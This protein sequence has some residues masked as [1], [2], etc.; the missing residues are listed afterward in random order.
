MMKAEQ[1]QSSLTFVLS[2][3]PYLQK[4][5]RNQ[6]H[7][8]HFIEA[9]ATSLPR[10]GYEIFILMEFCAGGGIIDLMNARLRDRLREEEVLKIFADVCDGLSVMHHLDPPMMHRDLKVE[11]ILLAP[12]STKSGPPVYKLCDFGSASPVLSR[13]APK[14]V[15]EIKRV[16]ADLNK[17]T[18]LQYRAPEMVDPYQRRVIDEKADIW[19]LGVLLYKLCYY[20]TPFE[21][22]GG[23]PLAILNARYRFPPH[24]PYSQRI[25][26]LIGEFLEIRK[27]NSRSHLAVSD[28]FPSRKSSSP[29]FQPLYFKNNLQL[30]L[31]LTKS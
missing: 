29:P 25:K 2:L 15:D 28:R 9:S 30:D 18:T 11:N 1:A 3:S 14:S 22:N 20:T 31:P 23:G 19:A 7:I 10:G 6:A 12:S 26:D 21:E 4:L 13:R 24:P 5:L 16:E 8:V 17:H 27:L